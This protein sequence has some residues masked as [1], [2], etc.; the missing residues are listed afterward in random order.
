MRWSRH[1]IHSRTLRSTSP[2][3]AETLATAITDPARAAA[4]GRLGSRRCRRAARARERRKAVTRSRAQGT[5]AIIR[6][7]TP[8]D[9]ATDEQ[10]MHRYVAGDA[11]AF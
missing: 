2:E 10:L 4:L 3:A 11:H 8:P 1:R 9:D 5:L 6:P 7:M